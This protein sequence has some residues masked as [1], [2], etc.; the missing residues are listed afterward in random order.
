MNNYYSNEVVIN[1]AKFREKTKEDRLKEIYS[2]YYR[3][4]KT[5]ELEIK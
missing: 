5:N 2:L 1:G 3:I 4:T